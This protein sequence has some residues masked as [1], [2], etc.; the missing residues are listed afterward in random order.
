MD[1]TLFQS[2]EELRRVL[3][4]VDP[5][6]GELPEGYESARGL[7]A[8]KASK[9]GAYI[10]QSEAEAAMIEAH[11][12]MLLDRV[13]TQKRRVEWLRAYLLENMLETGILE[14]AVESGSSIRL[15]PYRDPAVEIFDERQ[16]PAEYMADP[17]PPKPSKAKI[18]DAIKS[19]VEVPGALLVKRH[20]LTIK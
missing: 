1:L 5:D 18:L 9:V 4:Q 13:K 15:Y 12:K 10:L 16:I 2:S 11:A 19:G 6:T 8:N 14:V 20:R 17:V 7:V 3:D